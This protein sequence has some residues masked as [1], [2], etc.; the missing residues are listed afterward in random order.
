ML[1]YLVTITEDLVPTMI[2][3]S[4]LLAFFHMEHDRRGR[5]SQWIGTGAGLAASLAMAIAKNTTSK[6]ATN[7][8][9][10]YIFYVGIIA[11]VVFVVVSSIA[12]CSRKTGLTIWKMLTYI[13]GAVLTADFI[14]YEVPDVMAYPFNFDT[15]TK[16]VWSLE[17]LVRMI[18]YLLGLALVFIKDG[19][20]RFTSVISV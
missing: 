19:F 2:L 8:W 12:V 14:F 11:S 16:G 18:G 10:L 17:F 6:I 4:L 20:K 1:K 15:S 9:N 13:S 3:T 7:R 5:L